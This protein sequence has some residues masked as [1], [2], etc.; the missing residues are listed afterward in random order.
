MKPILPSVLCAAS[1]LLWNS[2]CST[3]HGAYLPENTT[4]FNQETTAKFVL[5]DPRTQ[6]SVTC[7]GLQEGF[8]SDGRLQVA[9]NVRNREN[10]RIEVQ[11]NCAFK[12]AQGFVTEESPFITL[13]LT[14]NET[15]T[16]KFD[17]MNDKAKNYT[18]RIRQTR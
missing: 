2:G 6:N 8:S 9:A 12:D 5:L 1:L 17:A 7:S 3:E 16:V 11:V 15:Q 14:E 4:Q 10:R 13:I 18:V